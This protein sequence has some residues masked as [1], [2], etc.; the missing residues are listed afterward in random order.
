MDTEQEALQKAADLIDQGYDYL[1]FDEP[2]RAMRGVVC[3]KGVSGTPGT[4]DYEEDCQ[5]IVWPIFNQPYETDKEVVSPRELIRFA[6]EHDTELC[7][8]PKALRMGFV[9]YDHVRKVAVVR[10][11]KVI[12]LRKA[13]KEVLDDLLERRD[14]RMAEHMRAEKVREVNLK[15]A[16]LRKNGSGRS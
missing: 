5:E 13:P 1:P 7:D 9:H 15:I 2:N 8:N 4:D 10:E 11:T 3:F 14:L 12:E 6:S 16:K